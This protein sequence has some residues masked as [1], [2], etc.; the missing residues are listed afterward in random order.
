[1]RTTSAFG[2]GLS[3][4]L[5][6]RQGARAEHGARPGTQLRRRL[7]AGGSETSAPTLGHLHGSQPVPLA[8]E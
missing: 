1:L 7:A 6:R 2:V 5:R 3:H 4:D 8:A